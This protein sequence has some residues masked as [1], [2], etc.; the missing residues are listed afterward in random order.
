MGFNSSLSPKQ[1]KHPRTP[2]R[3]EPFQGEES[4][5]KAKPSAGIFRKKQKPTIFNSE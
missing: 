4:A 3:I 1:P 2:V 5:E